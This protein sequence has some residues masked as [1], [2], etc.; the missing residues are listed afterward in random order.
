MEHWS[1]KKVAKMISQ[2]ALIC[3]IF[4]FLPRIYVMQ[5]DVESVIGWLQTINYKNESGKTNTTVLS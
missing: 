5:H 4:V 3:S 2:E 1:I